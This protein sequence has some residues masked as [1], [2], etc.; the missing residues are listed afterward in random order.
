MKSSSRVP[1]TH[2]GGDTPLP[3]GVEEIPYEVYNR[4]SPGR[5][6]TIVLVI[7]WCGL[8]SPISSTAVL[9][10]IPE[11]ADTYQTS[12]GIIALSNALYLVFMGVS[13]CFWGPLSQV[14]GRRWTCIVSATIFFACS[15]GTALAPTLAGFFVFRMLTA[16]AGTSFLVTGPAVIGD[17]YHPTARA[18]AMGWF[19]TGTLV[20]P[21][22][23]PLLGGVIVTYRSWRVIFWLQTALAGAGVA[24]ASFLLPETLRE[25]K[26]A[27]LEGLPPLRRAAVLWRL[28]N[29]MRVVKLFRFPNLLLTALASGALVFNMYGM[30]TP[31][32]YVLNPRFSLTSPAQSGL[33]Y[34]APGMGYLTGTLFGGRWADRTVRRWIERRSGRRV[35]EDRL[36][37]CLPFLGAALP[38]CMLIYGWSVQQRAGGIAVPVIFMFL[39][40]VAQLFCFPS[41]NTYCLDVM[42]GRSAEVIA[43]NFMVRYA[44]GAGASALVLPAIQAIGVGWFQTISAA[45]LVVGAAAVLAVA[46][47]GTG[48][49]TRIAEK[50]ALER[51]AL[52]ES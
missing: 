23:G 52:E 48:W 46:L 41:L 16:L 49:R 51:G 11:V 50:A 17:L 38:A 32:R 44:L 12:G 5:K 22:A 47:F 4:F 14:Y 31:I 42:Q 15:I 39:G 28:T 2:D 6:R 9:S 13:P 24:G 30:L 29:P 19:L 8:L 25:P 33:F 21:T 27:M 18:T 35:P 34:L 7:S 40:G 20:G 36:R 43:G 26:S 45:F 37:S 10:A 1:E 3:D